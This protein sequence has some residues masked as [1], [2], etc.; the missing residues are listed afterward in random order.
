MLIEIKHVPPVIDH[1]IYDYL[2]PHVLLRHKI[3]EVLSQVPE[4]D[5]F[6]ATRILLQ[7]W[8]N[9]ESVSDANV[10][11]LI[12]IITNL[13]DSLRRFEENGQAI[14]T[15]PAYRF[16]VV[17]TA[18][19][20]SILEQ[21]SQ[22]SMVQMAA[23]ALQQGGI[24]SDTFRN[25]IEQGFSTTVVDISAEA[26]R[27]ARV[28]L[29]ELI[30]STFREK[31]VGKRMWLV[32]VSTEKLSLF[33]SKVQ[34]SLATADE[35][36]CQELWTT[37]GSITPDELPSPNSEAFATTINQLYSAVISRLHVLKSESSFKLLSLYL[38][39]TETPPFTWYA[40]KSVG[41][42]CDLSPAKR[43]VFASLVESIGYLDTDVQSELFMQVAEVLRIG[44]DEV[45]LFHLS[46]LVEAVERAAEF[47]SPLLEVIRKQ[48]IKHKERFLQQLHEKEP[49]KIK[50]TAL[51]LRLCTL[52]QI[53][54]AS[55]FWITILDLLS[56]VTDS[57]TQSQQNTLKH[58]TDTALDAI[59]DANT[60]VTSESVQ[61]SEGMLDGLLSQLS[62]IQIKQDATI[63]A[64][65]IPS[66]ID[67][68]SKNRM[69]E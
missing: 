38:S 34:L 35:L 4:E 64:A 47:N 16:C 32:P 62:N 33:K 2:E 27:Q 55:E 69:V 54:V 53:C 10:H 48:V 7:R 40:N 6:N 45:L 49:S 41:Y 26:S 60:G 68:W 13:L 44:F 22:Q 21:H 57:L 65:Y 12:P 43:V 1:R 50:R 36:Y 46:T 56:D 20:L 63:D 30:S 58:L 29:A 5:G 14:M 9:P 3:E 59:V 39:L 23:D 15:V 61:R 52:L 67:N 37:I 66:L 19:A 11:E 28:H 24:S 8:L 25:I 17:M 42:R 51:F 31:R 18:V